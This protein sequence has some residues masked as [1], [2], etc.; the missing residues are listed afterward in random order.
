METLLELLAVLLLVLMNGFFVA[1]EFALVSAR[2][3]RIEQLAS[4]GNRT[5]AAAER[6]MNH[7]DSYIAGT[8][9]GITLASLALGWIGEPAVADALHPLLVIFPTELRDSLGHTIAAVVAFA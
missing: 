2:R 8:Q 6:A 9:L 3:T 4:E 7:L 1:T 5:A